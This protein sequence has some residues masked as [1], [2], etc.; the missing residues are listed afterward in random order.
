KKSIA[1]FDLV[2]VADFGH[3]CIDST[4]IEFLCSNAKYLAVNVQANSSNMGFNFISKYPR[5]DY[6]CI[7]KEE[8][9]LAYQDQFGPIEDLIRKAAKDFSTKLITIT[10]GV[11]GSLVY[12]PKRDLF[13]KTP[14]F[15][16]QVV[17]TTGAGDA[18]LAITSPLAANGASPELL[19]LVG[20]CVSALAVRV[21]GNRKP[22]EKVYLQKYIKALLA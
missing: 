6:L 11:N 2:L 3:G 7:D 15:S 4:V 20:N 18:F 22:V 5:I 14:I 1:D 16:Q 17:D 19:G 13:F 8:L 12:D 10:L 9:R 21:L